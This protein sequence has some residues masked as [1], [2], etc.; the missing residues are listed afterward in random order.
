MEIVFSPIHRTVHA[1]TQT[2]K[3][4]NRKETLLLAFYIP[5]RLFLVLAT[6]LCTPFFFD[7]L[8]SLLLFSIFLSILGSVSF[9]PSHICSLGL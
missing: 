5:I 9:P 3:C 4:F 8:H 1:L 2:P 7:F 6:A